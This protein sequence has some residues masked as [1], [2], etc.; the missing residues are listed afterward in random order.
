MF[1]QPSNTLSNYDA[2]FYEDNGSDVSRLQIFPL[3]GKSFRIS[4]P[5]PLAAYAYSPGGDAIYG[6][7]ANDRI[8]R[9]EFHPVRAL[10]LPISRREKR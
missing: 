5:F 8:F 6:K 7:A 1:G 4:L 3:N 2:A 10:A 9:I